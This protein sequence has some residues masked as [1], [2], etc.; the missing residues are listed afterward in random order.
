MNEAFVT[1]E[2]DTRRMHDLA[3]VF[4][5]V[6][7]LVAA[8]VCLT[9]MTR[10]VDE[11]RTLIGIF[12]A[13]GYS[14]ARI[15][16]RYLKYAV[17]ASLIGSLV[18]ITAGFWLIPTII[19]GAYGIVFALPDMTPA[20]YLGIGFMSVFATVFITT[21]STGIAARNSLRESP[22]DL[23]RPKA[24]KSGKRVFLEYIQA[25]WSRL[26]FT[27]KVTVRNLGL[28]KKRLLMSLVGIIGCTALVVTALGAKNAVRIL[29]DDQFG[30]IFHYNVTIG[31][32]EETRPLSL[33][34]FYLTKPILINRPKCSAVLLRQAWRMMIRT[35]ITFMSYLQRKRKDLP[36][37]SPSTIR[38]Q[39][40]TF[41]LQKTVR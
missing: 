35:P 37:S 7:F 20:F 34:P 15:A 10:M 2:G 23:M 17:S 32:N 21:L 9:T 6:F 29:L 19:W 25:V 28:N 5:M 22:A 16:G 13:L 41:L 38:K 40:E 4:P 14:N 36:T 8:L 33:P 18:G 26:T 1:Y 31:F 11:D 24:P 39:K 12:K 3:T 27:K 30:D